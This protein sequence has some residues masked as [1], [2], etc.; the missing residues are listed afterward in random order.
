MSYGV[1]NPKSPRRGGGMVFV[2]I[3][4]IAAYLLL[5]ANNNSSK[6]GEQ[7]GQS[8]NRKPT[9]EDVL[10]GPTSRDRQ[11]DDLIGGGGDFDGQHPGPS[12]RTT[13]ADDWSIES[14][15]K[16]N[17]LKP[18][19]ASNKKTTQGDW[20][21]ES[22]DSQTQPNT[23]SIRLGND[24]TKSTSG[25]PSHVSGGD[26]SIDDATKKPVEASGEANSGGD[27]KIESQ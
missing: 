9:P 16:S 1:P 14:V 5:S 21:I 25:N 12:G 20:S 27:W 22:V 10:G 8:T 15:Q 2:V 24:S 18:G 3:F 4:M 23:E 19:E 7:N 13:N 17:P 26:W 6:Q 11:I